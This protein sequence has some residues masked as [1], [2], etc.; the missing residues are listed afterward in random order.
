MQ[1]VVGCAQGPVCHTAADPQ[2]LHGIAAVGQVDLHLFQAAGYIKT[3]WTAAEHFLSAM[4]KAGGN[5]DGILFGDAAFDK[6]RRQFLRKIAQGDAAARVSRHG[7]NILILARKRKQY[8]GKSFSASYHRASSND[9]ILV[10]ISAMAWAYCS[11][12]GTP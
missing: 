8:I 10:S 2:N 5:A 6:L 7:H 3:S 11:S 4:G 12:V 1:T 9:L